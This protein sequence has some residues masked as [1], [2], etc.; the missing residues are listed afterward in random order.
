MFGK[1]TQKMDDKK[2]NEGKTGIAGSMFWLCIF[3]LHFPFAHF[4]FSPPWFRTKSLAR[5]GKKRR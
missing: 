1:H 3:R 5:L 2:M 4:P